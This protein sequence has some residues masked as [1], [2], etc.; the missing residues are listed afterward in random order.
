MHYLKCL[1]HIFESR[2]E[3]NPSYSLRSFARDLDLT[4]SF[5]SQ[6]LKG[7]KGLSHQKATEISQNLS[8]DL[9]E[10]EAF[11]ISNLAANARSEERKKYYQQKYDDLFR[12]NEREVPFEFYQTMTKWQNLALLEIIE[13]GIE[14]QSVKRMAS[15]LKLSEAEVLCN[16]DTLIEIQ[17]LSFDGV[18]YRATSEHSLLKGGIPNSYVKAFHQQILHQGLKAIE[19]QELEKREIRSSLMGISEDKVPEA[20]RMIQD[21]FRE[22]RKLQ[23]GDEEKNT[24]YALNV[25][26]IDLLSN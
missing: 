3:I 23:N 12:K 14:T 8:L 11:L 2:R 25:N 26:F 17:E 22:F 13:T 1:N 18:N 19:T 4:P 6:V 21:F 10:K 15:L 7:K 9:K 24:V 16:L 5:L 20:K